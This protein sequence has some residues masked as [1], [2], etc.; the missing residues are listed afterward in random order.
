LAFMFE[1]R[2]VLNPTRWALETPSLQGDYDAC[3]TGFPKNFKA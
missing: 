3:W 1:T 2:W